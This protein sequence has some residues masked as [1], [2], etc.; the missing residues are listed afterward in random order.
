MSVRVA[1]LVE[2]LR[3][4]A[5]VPRGSRRIGAE[6]EW[7]PVDAA[8]GRVGALPIATVRRAAA[9]GGWC[10]EPSP[11]GAPRFTLPGGGMVSFEPG[12][13]IEY[14]S[15]P[16]R[17]AS[18][19][20]AA[21]RDVFARLRRSADEDGLV[22]R[23]VGID[24]VTRPE[25]AA[26]R[27]GGHRYRAMDA[28]FRTIGPAGA[29]MMRQ[30]AAFQV[31]VDP[32]VDPGAD[33]RL[34]NALAP[35]VV[36]IFANSPVYARAET[37]CRSYRAETWRTLDPS[38][39]GIFA[40]DDPAAEYI[41]FALRAP[42]I[43]L[44]DEGESGES[45]VWRPFGE[46]LDEAAGAAVGNAESAAHLTTIDAEWAAHLT[47]MFPEVR[48]RGAFEVRSADAIDTE[49]AVVPMAL[50]GG[51]LYDGESARAAADVAGAPDAGRLVAAGRLGLRDPS[52]AATAAELAALAVAGCRRL[53]AGFLDPADLETAEEFFRRYTSR[54]RSPADD[55]SAVAALA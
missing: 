42:A 24:P 31:S 2:A 23:A 40:G 53:G 19:V 28:Y 17:S 52:I 55:A 14:S 50:L 46:W 41:A 36:A 6:A 9:G 13:Q 18:V 30:T 47:T 33:W 34:L 26:L 37:G 1:E 8:T 3:E 22:L 11:Y 4:Q 45:S 12:G 27:L 10:E 49:W 29:R 15:V 35:Y 48:P 38:R 54:G 43:L 16:S 5:F 44:G 51:L 39:T 7:I 21:V 25:C 20:A 32:G